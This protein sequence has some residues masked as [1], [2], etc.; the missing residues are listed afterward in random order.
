MKVY[1]CNNCPVVYI[2]ALGPDD[3]AVAEAFAAHQ[4]AH[5]TVGAPSPAAPLPT[6]HGSVSVERGN[7]A[8]RATVIGNDT[9]AHLP[10]KKMRHP[11]ARLAAIVPMFGGTS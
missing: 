8:S 7:I 6:T 10:A 11:S 1:R 5:N 2:G 4:R 3:L 9:Y